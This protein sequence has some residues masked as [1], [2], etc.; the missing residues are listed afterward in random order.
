[1]INRVNGLIRQN[2]TQKSF[3]LLISKFYSF[4]I[5]YL[6]LRPQK[7]PL[8]V[9]LLKA[10]ITNCSEGAVKSDAFA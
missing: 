2:T 9:S 6:S 3:L 10:T 8:Q 1:M 7:R 4:L 5:F